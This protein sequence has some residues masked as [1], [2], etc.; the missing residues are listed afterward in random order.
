MALLFFGGGWVGGKI[1][2]L[3]PEAEMLRSRGFVVALADYRVACRDGT[4][5]SEALDDARHAYNWFRANAN[6]FG[7]DRNRLVLAGASAGGHLAA[8]TAAAQVAGRR[9]AALVLFNPVVDLQLA[10]VQRFLSPTVD[11]LALSPSLQDPHLFPPTLIVHGE[12]DRTVPPASVAAFCQALRS[13]SGQ[14]QL[15]LYPGV[16]HGFF[17]RTSTGVSGGSDALFDSVMADAMAFLRQL[18]PAAL[19]ADSNAIDGQSGRGTTPRS[20]IGKPLV[21]LLHMNY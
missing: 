11:R 18:R 8:M 17:N 14:C 5:P 9:P 2:Q 13:A 19:K 7:G 6:R 21:N 12:Q 10:G 16:G 3:A 4:G 20:S 15:R 1:G